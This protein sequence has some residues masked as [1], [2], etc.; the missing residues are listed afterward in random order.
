MQQSELC[1]CNMAPSNGGGR[2]QKPAGSSTSARPNIIPAI[3]LPLVK[4][5]RPAVQH[6]SPCAVSA[7]VAAASFPSEF[8]PPALRLVE[9]SRPSA[10]DSNHLDNHFADHEDD[11]VPA[12]TKPSEPAIDQT[13]ATTG[14]G[15]TGEVVTQAAEPSLVPVNSEALV[16]PTPSSTG[17]SRDNSKGMDLYIEI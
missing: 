2:G 3:P 13:S 8:S 17:A 11:A 14:P 15:E 1:R 6:S 12:Q 10:D 16:P 9:T 5:P 4:K 7:P